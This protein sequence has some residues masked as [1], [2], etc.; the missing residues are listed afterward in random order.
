A[1]RDL[2]AGLG[3]DL[4]PNK[5]RSGRD[6]PG[7]G[8]VVFPICPGGG[9][10]GGEGPPIRDRHGMERSTQVGFTRLARIS[11]PISG[12]PEIGVCSAPLRAALRPGHK[13]HVAN[14]KCMTSPSATT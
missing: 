7:G 3:V 12:K 14:L 4:C 2:L 13:I 1:C 8:E 9:A 10:G 5:G 6:P 11:A